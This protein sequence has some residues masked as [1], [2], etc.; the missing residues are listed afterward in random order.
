MAFFSAK[1]A[2]IAV[3]ALA[4]ADLEYEMV[5]KQDSLAH[6]RSVALFADRTC[7]A[8]PSTQRSGIERWLPSPRARRRDKGSWLSQIRA[9]FPEYDGAGPLTTRLRRGDH[10][11]WKIYNGG[12][13]VILR[14]YQV[15]ELVF[16]NLYNDFYQR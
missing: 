3:A 14:R 13:Q 4:F 2:S 8:E 1:F 15:N 5:E 9:H 12:F 7:L 16:A 11:S 10:R 6:P